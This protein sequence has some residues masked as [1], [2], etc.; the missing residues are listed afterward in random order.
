MAAVNVWLPLMK[1]SLA[2]LSTLSVSLAT[3]LLAAEALVYR[4]DPARV[5][6]TA[7]VGIHG[8]FLE[9]IFN[10]VHGGLWGDLLLNPSLEPN[11]KAGGWLRKDDTVTL[12][13]PATNQPLLLG[14][15]G[16][17]DYQVTLEARRDEGAE[18]FLV[19]FRVAG[20]QYYWA[21]FG[22]WGNQQHG[23][24]KCGRPLRN[25]RVP[26]TIEAGRW[27]QS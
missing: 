14:E 17:T 7:S 22:G 10:S 18:G 20:D 4:I 2:I 6:R 3:P 24:E 12:A 15:P 25:V 11:A 23:V 16:W 21:N 8:Q 9:H 13:A 1:L 26:G 19:M 5:A 27:Y